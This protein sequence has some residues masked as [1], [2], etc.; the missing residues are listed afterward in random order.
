[1]DASGNAIYAELEIILSRV[2]KGTCQV[3]LRFTDPDSEAELSS[4]KGDAPIFPAT[5]AKLLDQPDELAKELTNALFKD[6]NIKSLYKHAKGNTHPLRIRLTIASGASEL[7]EIPWELLLDPDP[8]HNHLATSE[9]I[10]FSRFM[11]SSDWSAVKLNRKADLKALIAVSGPTDYAARGLTEVKVDDVVAAVRQ[12]LGTIACSVAGQSEPLTRELFVETLRK[13]PDIVYL[14]CHGAFPADAEPVLFFQDADGTAKEL[15]AG[16]FAKDIAGLPARPRLM[17]LAS[18]ESA[19]HHGIVPSVGSLAARL[20]DA[21]VPAIL[22]MQGRVFQTTVEQMMPVFFRELL[23]DGQIDRALGLA[24][25]IA[26]GNFDFWIPAL[27]L[28]LRGGRIWYVPG[29]AGQKDDFEWKSI[30]RFV[31]L[32]QFVPLLGPDLAEHV[33]GSVRSL[34][35]DLAADNG[36]PFTPA[37]RS[38]LA[39]VAQY[40]AAKSS[41][42]DARVQIRTALLTNLV[43]RARQRGIEVDLNGGPLA[44]LE[45]AADR[46]AKDPQDPLCILASLGAKF[47]VNAAADPLFEMVLSRVG[48]PPITP[49]PYALEWRDERRADTAVDPGDPSVDKPLL[50]YVY[51]TI[52]QEETWL[53][54]EDDFFD[55]L[56]RVSEFRLM[57]SGIGEALTG[58][59]LGGSLLFLGFPL[60]DW[61]FRILLRMILSKRG[62]RKLDDYNHVGVQVDPEEYTFADALR[63]KTNLERYFHKTKNINIY[64]GSAADFLQELQK[65]MRSLKLEPLPIPPWAA[66]WK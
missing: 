50:Y 32:G 23:V 65:Q 8:P 10:L 35:S 46:A 40:I 11:Q 4:E 58:G 14:V 26:K 49:V 16:E 7:N 66:P 36:Y 41:I 61:K 63:A 17:V 47:F 45:A 34:A 44:I 60:H 21:G 53:L 51:G 57:P 37:D 31:K 12:S 22:A 13:A 9:R 27:F 20:A 62:N 6:A 54:T 59:K 33:Y 3:E 24:R 43:E 48:Q 29:F 15:E 28:R 42:E 5:L 2:V 52:L 1:M 64:W 56:I 39:R 18:C 19:G 25:L 30:C 38:D 55:Y